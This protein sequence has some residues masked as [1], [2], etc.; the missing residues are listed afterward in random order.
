V[1]NVS[2]VYL[3]A[4]YC[5]H[6]VIH[7]VTVYNGRNTNNLLW[8]ATMRRPNTHGSDCIRL[9]LCIRSARI[10]SSACRR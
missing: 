2:V 6:A 10:I 4:V 7:A 1:N 3:I 8:Y 9:L 5:K